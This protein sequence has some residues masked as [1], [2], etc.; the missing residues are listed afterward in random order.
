MGAATA[1]RFRPRPKLM[2]RPLTPPVA[3]RALPA[4]S[5]AATRSQ[6]RFHRLCVNRNGFPGPKRLSSTMCSAHI[7]R[8]RPP[9]ISQLCRCDPASGARSPPRCSRTVRL[10][11][12]RLRG[13][14]TRGRED[15]APLVD[16]CNRCDR[17]AQPPDRPNPAHHTQGRPQAQLQQ[18]A[19]D[20]FRRL[21][22]S[23]GRAAAPLSEHS[24]PR[25]TGQER[26]KDRSPMPLLQHDCSW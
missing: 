11:P 15:H 17:R 6:D 22:S 3:P 14:F 20:G 26:D 19:S 18:A 21:P 9:P 10:D 24:Q 16:F 25:V 8:Q 5:R 13:F 7:R 12:R 23:S 2:I 1:R 4:K